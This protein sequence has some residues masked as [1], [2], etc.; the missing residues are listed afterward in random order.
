MPDS[1]NAFLIRRDVS[2]PS[3]EFGRLTKGKRGALGGI[4]LFQSNPIAL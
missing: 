1:P 3:E 2:H 4:N